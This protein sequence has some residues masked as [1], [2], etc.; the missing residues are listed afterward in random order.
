MLDETIH[1]DDFVCSLCGPWSL[2]SNHGRWSLHSALEQWRQVNQADP[3]RHWGATQARYDDF[4]RGSGPSANWVGP[5]RE[6]E[7]LG[8]RLADTGFCCNLPG[9]LCSRRLQWIQFWGLV[10]G[11]LDLQV[12]LCVLVGICWR[13]VPIPRHLWYHGMRNASS[14][15][16]PARRMG[17][18]VPHCIGTCPTLSC[19]VTRVLALNTRVPALAC[20][21]LTPMHFSGCAS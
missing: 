17:E 19:F 12:A 5:D 9:R 14:C 16:Q 20:S 21:A 18:P 6:G 4:N 11:P 2:S 3:S 10:R 1:L 15:Q 8:K 7:P 13:L